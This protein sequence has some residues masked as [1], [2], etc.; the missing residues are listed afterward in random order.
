MQQ[1]IKWSD[2]E[3]RIANCRKHVEEMRYFCEKYVIQ[4]IDVTNNQIPRARCS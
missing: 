4:W 2:K 1:M 3:S